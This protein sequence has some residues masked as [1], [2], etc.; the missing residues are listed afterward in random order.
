MGFFVAY[1]IIKLYDQHTIE[2]IEPKPIFFYRTI[3]TSSLL[4]LLGAW[5]WIFPSSRF[6]PRADLYANWQ[7]IV[8]GMGGYQAASAVTGF[9]IQLRDTQISQST[10]QWVAAFLPIMSMF[11]ARLVHVK[12][13]FAEFTVGVCFSVAFL[14]IGSLMVSPT[15][16][17]PTHPYQGPDNEPWEAKLLAALEGLFNVLKCVCVAA[18]LLKAGKDEDRRP[19]MLTSVLFF[20][21]ASGVIVN[22]ALCLIIEIGNKHEVQGLIDNI[23]SN[24]TNYAKDNVIINSLVYVVI[25]SILYCI[26]LPTQYH[27]IRMTSALSMFLVY[28]FVVTLDTLSL[29]FVS[30][31]L[32][33][34][35]SP[36]PQVYASPLMWMGVVIS[37][38]SGIAYGFETHATR[39]T[40][41]LIRNQPEK[42]RRHH[43]CQRDRHGAT[44]KTPL[45]I[46][47]DNA[48][49]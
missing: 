47:T 22:G 14:T 11:I 46:V 45:N 24:L 3:Q 36:L 27:L 30:V 5:C 35:H 17:S 41:E 44:E 15:G 31:S 1:T 18:L 42:V 8:L 49:G 39:L 9:L 20:D 28:N 40:Q 37:V 25:G 6:S 16:N 19:L 43:A 4:I 33:P 7:K 48:L 29:V 12:D 34:D 13:F 2:T 21:T 38:I 10:S 32:K 23:K 26:F